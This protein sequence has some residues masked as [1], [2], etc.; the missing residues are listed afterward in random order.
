[1]AHHLISFLGAGN[2]SAKQYFQVEY[3]RP[4]EEIFVK[5]SITIDAILQLYN[6]AKFDTVHIIGTKESLWHHAYGDLAGLSIENE[7]ITQASPDP[8]LFREK[9]G[10]AL[11][12]KYGIP[13]Q[14]HLISVGEYEKDI[15]TVF[16]AI[17]EIPEEGDMISIDFTYGLRFQ[18]F[19]AVLAVAY[20]KNVKEIRWKHIFYGASDLASMYYAKKAPIID[21]APTLTLFDWIDAVKAFKNYGDTNLLASLMPEV[22]EVASKL[23]QS[24]LLAQLKDVAYYASIFLEKLESSSSDPAGKLILPELQLLGKKFMDTSNDWQTLRTISQDSF[25]YGQL[26]TSVTACWEAVMVRFARAYIQPNDYPTYQRISFMVVQEKYFKSS[27]LGNKDFRSAAKQLQDFRN[28]L[29]HS[30][31][32]E[33]I[34]PYELMRKFPELQNRIFTI[35]ENET[36]FHELPKKLTWE[37]IS[38]DWEEH[39]KRRK[40]PVM[41]TTSID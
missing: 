30:R 1:M 17:T 8:S 3:F 12:K 38:S 35:L 26:L 31:F 27:I 15:W 32:N 29:A 41:E 7:E 16:E 24:I 6:D 20:F 13:V 23:S 11:Q 40:Q 5:A 37:K 22:R 18:P 10:E 36:F 14:T 9:A 2:P 34:N 21:L 19:A 39:E 4:K 33:G 28:G 25:R